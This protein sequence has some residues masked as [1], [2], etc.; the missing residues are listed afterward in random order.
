MRTMNKYCCQ[1][2]MRADQ[3]RGRSFP[4]SL[5]RSQSRNIMTEAAASPLTHRYK[6]L[7]RPIIQRLVP[8]ISI[9][10]LRVVTTLL[11]QSI[12]IALFHNPATIKHNNTISVPNRREAMRYQNS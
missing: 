6:P 5:W 12:V 8:P 3:A 1:E 10:K 7:P 2:E 11:H 9:I 4:D